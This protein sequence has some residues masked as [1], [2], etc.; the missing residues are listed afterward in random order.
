MSKPTQLI[1]IDIPAALPSLAVGLRLAFSLS[2]VGVVF[3][4]IIASKAGLG[5]VIIA[6][7]TLAQ[8]DL[9]GAAVLLL[10]ATSLVG[11]AALWTL[12]QRMA[13]RWS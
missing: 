8:Y 1:K 7:Y 6:K 11:T 12:E 4:E 13:N 3:A 9:M 5:Q 10:V 2:L